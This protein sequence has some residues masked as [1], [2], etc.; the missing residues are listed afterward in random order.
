MMQRGNTGEF[1]VE[2][3]EKIESCIIKVNELKVINMHRF[4]AKTQREAYI[5]QKND[6]KLL[7]NSLLID[8]DFKQ[9]IVIG[10][11]NRK[12]IYIYKN[13]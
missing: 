2:Q 8:I 4:V 5:N 11:I 6:T 13:Y 9:K 3:K 12:I 1:I 10:K 7:L